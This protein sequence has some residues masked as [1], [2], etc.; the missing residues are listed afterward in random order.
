MKNIEIIKVIHVTETYGGG[1]KTY[2]NNLDSRPKKNFK[3]LFI[4]FGEKTKNENFFSFRAYN[5]VLSSLLLLIILPFF[6][7]FFKPKIIHLHCFVAGLIGRFYSLFFFK[8]KF[9]YQPH[10][11]VMFSTSNKFLKYTFYLIE[12]FFS[13]FNSKTIACSVSECNE[14]NKFTNADKVILIEN[15]IN[16]QVKI[17]REINKK[18][19]K[20]FTVGRI[21]YQKNPKNFLRLAQ[22]FENKN[23]TFTW[24]GDGHYKNY[25]RL[26]KKNN[27]FITGWTDQENVNK[28]MNESNIFVLLSRYEGMSYALLQALSYGLPSVVTNVIGNK[29]LVVNG[30]DGFVC[31]NL[32]EV[33]KRIDQMIYDDVLYKTLSRNAQESIQNKYNLDLQLKKIYNAYEKSIS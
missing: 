20:I 23:V 1:I 4:T 19:I 3:N 12:M 7:I 2:L 10:G 16:P 11:L 9:F 6:I 17:K 26:F 18:N 25:K 21:C 31:D 30:I 32:N 28:I 8:I 22:N 33:K 27:I 5:R 14:I 29:D 15:G 13:K 24:I